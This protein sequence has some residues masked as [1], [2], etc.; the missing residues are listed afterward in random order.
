MRTSWIWLLIAMAGA[1]NAREAHAQIA[2]TLTAVQPQ[3]QPK[4]QPS[5]DSK[6]EPPRPPEDRTPRTSYMFGGNVRLEVTITDQR[7]A[8][9]ATTKTVSLVLASGSQGRI[10]TTGEVRVPS[11]GASQPVILNVDANP[12]VTPE[13]RVRASVTLEYR[14]TAGAA[15]SEDQAMT[16]VSETF[17][18]MLDDGKP[19][20]VTQSADPTTDRRVRVEVKATLL[21]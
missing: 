13:N 3:A 4:P 12:H 10:R 15:A 14:P 21:K 19:L 6:E 11:T 5:S 9:Q 1:I 8:A 7:A 16:A 2:P 17:T 20:V 18:V